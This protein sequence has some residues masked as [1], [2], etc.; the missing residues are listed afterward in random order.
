M[1]VTVQ[2]TDL[3]LV[4]GS[5]RN[6]PRLQNFLTALSMLPFISTADT[7]QDSPGGTMNRR[8][9][10]ALATMLLLFE[11]G[12]A[13]AASLDPGDVIVADQ[14]ARDIVRVN[15]T[16]GVQAIISGDGV[17]ATPS[18]VAITAS[19][20]LFVADQDALGGAIIRVDPA[21]GSQ[22][23]ITSG[24]GFV[25]PGGI[26][27]AADGSLIIADRDARTIV[28]VNPTTGDRTVISSG[29]LFVSPVSV[30]I[31][32]ATGMLVVADQDAFGAP[33]SGPGAVIR[34]DPATGAQTAVSSAGLFFN[35]RGI[36]IDAAGRYIVSD[37]GDSLG[38]GQVIRVDSVS[39]SQTLL[40]AAGFLGHITG[41]AIDADGN[42]LLANEQGGGGAGVIRV[43]HLTGVQTLVSS[44]GVFSSPTGITI[45]GASSPVPE[46]STFL[47]LASG[48]AGLA[49]T[50][51]RARRK[52]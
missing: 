48:L 45:V 47:L 27:I 14:F 18:A 43:D 23:V 7:L 52:A 3:V 1:V 24:G 12:A 21:T 51:W 35:P 15:P 10:T 17:F 11:S 50:A 31:D 46:P 39:G 32:R 25:N 28:R 44:G 5:S 37:G 9:A 42:F 26:A 19:G 4:S 13:V 49:G 40:S 22:T 34:V 38:P 30:A 2:K 6:L 8:V 16:T 36:A 41:I 33:G 29:G 20:D